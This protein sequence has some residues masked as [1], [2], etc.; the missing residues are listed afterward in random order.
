M[1]YASISESDN[2]ESRQIR[3]TAINFA[4]KVEGKRAPGQS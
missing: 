3:A 4:R 1:P 2:K